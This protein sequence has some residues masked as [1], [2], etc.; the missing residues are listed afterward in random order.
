MIVANSLSKSF[1]DPR[2]GTIQAVK[3][4]DFSARPGEITGL[5][6]V[7]GAGKTTVLRILSTVIRPSGGRAEVLGFDVVRNAEDVRR[8]I[9]FLSNTTALY[10]RLTPTEILHYFGELNGIPKARLKSRVSEVIELLGIGSFANQLCD[11]LST[12]QKQRTSI[13]RAILHDPPVLFFD[14]PTAGLDVVTSQTILEFIE[15]T[16]NQGK[17]VIYSTHIMSE[18]ERLCDH[19]T[20]IHSGEMVGDGNLESL[21]AQTGETNLE[22]AFLSLVGYRG[23]QGS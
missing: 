12:G 17:T 8:S 20:I 5:L 3:G 10:G 14:E 9:G 4:F 11:K 2:K 22:R 19:I 1:Q 23:G 18:V 6:G 21:L 15:S 13:A 16:R 7:N